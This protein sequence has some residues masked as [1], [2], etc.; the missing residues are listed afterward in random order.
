MK[1]LTSLD[2]NRVSGSADR[3]RA[4]RQGLREQGYVEGHNVA[5]DFRWA[6]D[7]PG[8]LPQLACRYAKKTEVI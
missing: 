4:F 6:D 1:S 8:R 2:E 3:V 5:I 7:E